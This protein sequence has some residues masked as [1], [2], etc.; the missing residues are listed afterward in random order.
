M[1]NDAISAFDLPVLDL[2]HA[3]VARKVI[4]EG[5]AGHV[6]DPRVELKINDNSFGYSLVHDFPH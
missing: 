5:A 4:D 1:E 2:D 6:A 3:P